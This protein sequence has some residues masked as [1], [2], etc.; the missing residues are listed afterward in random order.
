LYPVD[1][2]RFDC[3]EVDFPDDLSRAQALF[4]NKPSAKLRTS[5]Q[6]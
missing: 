5:K 3:L 1:I 4:A 6:T 2:S